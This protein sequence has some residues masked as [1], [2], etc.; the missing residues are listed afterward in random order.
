M[1]TNRTFNGFTYDD[2]TDN[3]Q[4][5]HYQLLYAKSFSNQL[6]FNGALHYTKGSGYYE[7]FKEDQA[8]ADYGLNN[9]VLG[10]QTIEETNL[11]RRRWL[12]NDFYGL[13][14]SLN[15]KPSNKLDFT[16]GGAYN[17]YDGDHF[18]EV[19]WAQFASNGNIRERYYFD[20]GFKTDFNLKSGFSL[21]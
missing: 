4:Q 2:Q 3:Y 14:Y 21:S 19:I 9:V 11:I 12:D 7:E 15:Y 16:L 1:A 10:N 18:G 8:F 17:E 6:S 20:N 5:D 13:T